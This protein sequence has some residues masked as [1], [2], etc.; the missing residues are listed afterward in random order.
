MERQIWKP[1][2][3]QASGHW[4]V[5]LLSSGWMCS[6]GGAGAG[7]RPKGGWCRGAGPMKPPPGGT[8]VSRLWLLLVGFLC[9]TARPMGLGVCPKRTSPRA[10]DPEQC[11]MI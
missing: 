10:S 9:Q 3:A 5:R 11:L 1:S 8:L 4:T 7:D 2:Q 6:G